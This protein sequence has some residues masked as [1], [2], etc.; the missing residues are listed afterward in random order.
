MLMI[1]NLDSNTPSLQTRM[2]RLICKHPHITRTESGR[3]RMPRQV[4]VTP[5]CAYFCHQLW[6]IKGSSESRERDSLGRIV[7][8]FL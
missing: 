5:E 1:S 7:F 4:T 2:P 6:K 8:F 3:A